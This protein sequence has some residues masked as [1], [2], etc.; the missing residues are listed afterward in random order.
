MKLLK[1]AGAILNQTPLDWEGNKRNIV[2]AIREAKRQDVS[3]LCLP[4]LAITGYGCEDAFYAPDMHKTA[5]EMLYDIL[6]ETRDMV[7]CVGL[8]MLFQNRNFN[9]GAMIVDGKVAGFVAKRYLAGSGVYYEPR[10]FTPWP[11]GSAAKVEFMG[12][13]YPIGDLIFEIDGVKIGLEICEDAWVA[14]RPGRRLFQQGIDLILNPSASHFAFEKLDIRKRFVMEGSRSFGTGYVYANL[15]GNDSGRMIFDGG[16]L[17]ASNGRMLAVGE[18]LSF[19][20]YQITAAVI[21]IEEARMSQR[22]TSVPFSL[23]ETPSLLIHTQYKFPDDIPNQSVTPIRDWEKSTRIKEEEFARVQALGL[24]DYMRKSFS[25]GFVI[26]LSGGADSSAIVSCCYLM[27]KLAIENLGI[28]EFKKKLSYF[29]EIQHCQTIEEFAQHI[30]TAAYQ[31]T[32][33]SGQ[34]TFNAAKGLATALGAT[35][36]VFNVNNIFKEYW[37]IIE[38]QLGR[39]LDWNKDDIALQN[40]QA[41][42][43]APSV[44]MMAN[45]KGALLLSTSNRSEAAVGYATMDGDTSGGLSPIAGIDKAFLRKWLVWLEKEGISMADGSKFTIPA[46]NAVNVQA[47]TAELRPQESKQ[48]DEADLM[49]YELLEAIEDLAIR[50]KKMPLECYLLVRKQFPQYEKTQLKA[51][52]TKFFKLW[53]RNQWKRERYAPSFHMDDRNLDPKTWCRFPILSGG[54]SYELKLLEEYVD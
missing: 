13:M 16:T 51:W 17:I 25:K 7:V 2:Q 28:E 52:V 1:V 27:I 49:P 38:E 45:L 5:L 15:V 36:Y 47:P 26:S 3:V 31:P 35:F 41:R 14:S 19:Q 29:K 33:N 18:R 44:W 20:D 32:E 53:C 23:L 6:P 34:V 8:P 39:P 11:E 48:T 40:I 22:Q 37:K 46:L 10:W 43:R 9:T 50:D 21:D 24:F 42:V 12:E 4:E 54:F 30:I